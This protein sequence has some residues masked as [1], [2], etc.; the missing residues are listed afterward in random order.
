MEK[1]RDSVNKV[2]SAEQAEDLK[3]KEKRKREREVLYCL[4]DWDLCNSTVDHLLILL[5]IMII[6]HDRKICLGSKGG[7]WRLPENY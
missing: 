5:I 7:S 6:V 1:G 2:V 3:M 4:G